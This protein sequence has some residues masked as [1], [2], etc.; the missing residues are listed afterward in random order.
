MSRK[1]PGE[2]ISTTLHPHQL[3]YLAKVQTVSV[4]KIFVIVDFE[5]DGGS[6][7]FSRLPQILWHGTKYPGYAGMSHGDV[8]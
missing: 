2:F 5:N 7:M 3:Q 1:S 8:N 4:R 6:N